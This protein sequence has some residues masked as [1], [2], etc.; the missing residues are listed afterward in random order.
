MLNKEKISWKIFAVIYNKYRAINNKQSLMR[1]Y[2]SALV[3]GEMINLY[4][5]GP[6]LW[7]NQDLM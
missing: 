5:N 4:T 6:K 3:G 1:C 2:Y 7:R